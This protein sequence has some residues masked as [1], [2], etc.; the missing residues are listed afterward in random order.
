MLASGN[1]ADSLKGANNENSKPTARGHGYSSALARGFGDSRPT[2]G[3][4]GEGMDGSD[5]RACA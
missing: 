3:T 4:V 5:G 2:V 1:N